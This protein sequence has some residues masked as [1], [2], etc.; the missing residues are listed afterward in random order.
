MKEILLILAIVVIN[1]M[2]TSSICRRWHGCKPPKVDDKTDEKKDIF[3]CKSVLATYYR[4]KY[5][6]VYI[7]SSMFFVFILV[8]L[9]KTYMYIYMNMC[10]YIY[11][12]IYII[13]MHIYMSMYMYHVYIY[14]YIYRYIYI[15]KIELALTIIPTYLQR[16][17]FK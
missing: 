16:H 2:S 4:I 11:I 1:Q 5:S 17:L 14:I 3:N 12:Y 7:P 10:I 8:F 13:F 9:W 6:V 15:I